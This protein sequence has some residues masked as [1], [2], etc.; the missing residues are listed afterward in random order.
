MQQLEAKRKEAVELQQQVQE[1]TEQETL[2]EGSKSEENRTAP[3]QID[4]TMSMVARIAKLEAKLAN[5]EELIDL[6]V[7]HSFETQTQLIEKKIKKIDRSRKEIQ[8]LTHKNLEILATTR[9]LEETQSQ[10]LETR[11]TKITALQKQ[12]QEF[13]ANADTHNLQINEIQRIQQRER[14]EIT[15]LRSENQE[16]KAAV[17]TP[18][19]GSVF[20]QNPPRPI[21]RTERQALAAG[22]ADQLLSDLQQ[23]LQTITQEKEE[24]QHQLQRDASSGQVTLP[25]SFT[26]PRAQVYHKLLEHTEPLKSVM[27]YYQAYRALDLLTSNLPMLKRGITLKQVQ[28][29]DLWD[30]ANSRARDT[31]AFMWAVGD[32]KPPLGILEIVTGSPPFFIRRYILRSV[33]FLAQHRATH[34][35]G[36]NRGQTLPNLRPY[37][38]SQK[39]AIIKLQNQNRLIFQKAT[40][41]LRREDTTICYEAVRRHQWL[42]EHYPEQATNVTLPQLKE[43]VTQTLQEQQ[44]TITKG[45]VGTINHGTILQICIPDRSEHHHRGHSEA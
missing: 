43:Y 19:T 40:E 42:L 2:R 9:K 4:M 32:L 1:L 18:N 7:E 30:Q 38:H 11:D 5:A 16:L 15:A 14:A 6:Y 37:T 35:K 34:A 25:H 29:T 20:S 26:H 41:S 21:D 44:I 13:Q 27:Q 22:V 28:F 39:M 23:E 33:A 8:T 12:I 36:H 31:L 45:R 17:S 10:Q 24:L 3:P